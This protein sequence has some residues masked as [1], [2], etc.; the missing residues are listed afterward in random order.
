MCQ[1]NLLQTDFLVSEAVN[2]LQLAQIGKTYCTQLLNT[3]SWCFSACF[4]IISHTQ[5]NLSVKLPKS[6]ESHSSV[7]VDKNNAALIHTS[8]QPPHKQLT[9][10][11]TMHNSHAS[12]TVK[13]AGNCIPALLV[14]WI[15]KAIISIYYQVL[16]MHL[17]NHFLMQLV[18]TCHFLQ[19][20]TILVWLGIKTNVTSI[21]NNAIIFVAKSVSKKGHTQ[22]YTK[23]TVNLIC[24]K[25]CPL[26][27]TFH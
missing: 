4:S 21:E 11:V 5:V 9:D 27:V 26:S 13:E 14:K 20:Q 12:L 18:P 3:S 10:T 16:T 22:G 2:T 6:L 15:M 24:C 1:K 19:R 23:G 8:T 25:T 7:V 17:R